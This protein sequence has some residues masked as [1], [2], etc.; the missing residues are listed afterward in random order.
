MTHKRTLVIL[1]T[2]KMPAKNETDLRGVQLA[3]GLLHSYSSEQLSDHV[4]S[5]YKHCI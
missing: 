4:T 5:E 1:E 2:T 3:R